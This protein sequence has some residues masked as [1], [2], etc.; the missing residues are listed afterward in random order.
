MEAITALDLFP[1]RLLTVTRDCSPSPFTK[2]YKGLLSQKT[3]RMILFAGPFDDEFKEELMAKLVAAR[4]KQHAS[5]PLLGLAS[6]R[7]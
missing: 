3:K 6:S 4:I 5:I 1:W 2:R 7:S